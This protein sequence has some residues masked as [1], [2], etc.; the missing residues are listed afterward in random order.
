VQPFSIAGK[1]TRG[2]DIIVGG[3]GNGIIYGYGGNDFICGGVGEA[4]LCKAWKGA[5][6]GNDC[7]PLLTPQ[8]EASVE[9]ERCRGRPIDPCYVARLRHR[10]I[11]DG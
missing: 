1:G 3:E 2:K 8:M 6:I 4:F 9:Q 11:G 10:E 7:M 5:A